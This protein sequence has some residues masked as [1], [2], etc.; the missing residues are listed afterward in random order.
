MHRVSLAHAQSNVSVHLRNA[1]LGLVH[2]AVAHNYVRYHITFQ[3][4]ASVR[5]HC[6]SQSSPW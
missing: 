1:L 5:W 2:S 3:P 6:G 4:L